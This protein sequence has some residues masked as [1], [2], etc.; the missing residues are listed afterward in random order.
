MVGAA[1]PDHDRSFTVEVRIGDAILGRGSGKSK[2][3]AETEAARLAL[4][5]LS[6]DFTP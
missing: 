1:G 5:R 4:E 2:K 3:S 6:T